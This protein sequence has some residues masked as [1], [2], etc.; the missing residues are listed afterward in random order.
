MNVK[1]LSTSL[2]ILLFVGVIVVIVVCFT[3]K[4]GKRDDDEEVP[5]WKDCVVY[6]VYPRSLQDGDA[7]GTGDL[8]GIISKIDYLKDL[9]IGA[10]WLSPIYTSPMADFG[11]DISN[12]TDIDPIFGNMADFD[13]LLHAFHQKGIKVLMDF[14]PNHSSDEHEWFIKSVKQEEPYTDY[15]IWSD[16]LGFNETG[17]PIPP[18]N[19][20]SVFR[21]SAWTWVE[22]RQQF[23]FHQFLDKQPDLNYRDPRV[24][25]EM[26]KIIRFWLDK[27][28]DG[29][30]VDAI[31]HLVEVKDIHQD[32]PVAE[33]S[34]IDDPMD[35]NYLNHTLTVEQPETFDVLKEW[36]ELIDQYT[37]KLL[38]VEEYDI[39]IDKVMAYYGNE[40]V[41]L[42]DF[43]FNFLMIGKLH[44][45]TDL[46]GR[47]LKSIVDMWLD[48]MPD[49]KWANWVLGNHDTS[50]VGSRFGIDLVDSLNM[51]SLL[52]PGTPVTYY[53]EEIGMMDTWI[54]WEDTQDPQGCRYGPEHYAEH[55]RDPARTP[56]QW[57]NTT[58][59]GFTT[60]ND[61]WLPVNENYKTLNVKAQKEA[62]FS[63]LKVY[64]S[65]TQ[66]RKEESFRKGKIAYPVVTEDIFSFVRYTEKTEMYLLVINTS[67]R[68]IVVDLHHSASFQLPETGVVVLRSVTDT[69][70]ETVPGSEVYLDNVKMVGGEGLVFSLGIQS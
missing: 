19:W 53:G 5:F 17:E 1:V 42:A 18:N 70:E 28:V 61:T 27:G 32:E 68:E 44:N 49:G 67:E 29:F 43:P 23:Y 60:G 24:R 64:Q 41:P 45:R 7:D 51:M 65:L 15:Y 47:T 56:M 21:G 4:Y 8:K 22:E 35:Y 26:L 57:D 69:S 16:P 36:R 3:A 30:R 6:Q 12:F 11:Y 34:G 13:E 50:R 14:V 62:E 66:L 39:D 9:G 25:E 63:H 33:D 46:S 31:K 54:S 58:L 40:T 59:A 38:M 48:N 20:L 55:S 37:D 10:A 52:L 2:F